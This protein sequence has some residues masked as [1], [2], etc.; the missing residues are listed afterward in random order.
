MLSSLSPNLKGADH[1]GDGIV[2]I[3]DYGI[4]LDNFTV[5]GASP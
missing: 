4:V 2:D 5:Q 1:N 3:A